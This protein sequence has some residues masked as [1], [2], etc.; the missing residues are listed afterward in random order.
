MVRLIDLL[1]SGKCFEGNSWNADWNKFQNVVVPSVKMNAE[2]IAAKI[3]WRKWKMQEMMGEIPHGWEPHTRADTRA[4]DEQ[5]YALGEQIRSYF[6]KGG[7]RGR[8]EERLNGRPLKQ[9]DPDAELWMSLTL[10]L[11]DRR[12]SSTNAG[13]LRVHQ[14][15]KAQNQPKERLSPFGWTQ[16]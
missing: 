4:Q 1:Y 5:V 16:E 7:W 15:S 10:R 3:P 11:G 6:A 13:E 12:S 2:Q 14:T 9:D 8:L